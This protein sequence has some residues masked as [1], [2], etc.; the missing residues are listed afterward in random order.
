M[1]DREVSAPVFDLAGGLMAGRI[2]S[3][4][5]EILDDE[6]V[7]TLSDE[8]WRMWVSM[9]LLADDCGN[10]RA[11]DRYLAS[12][13]WQDSTRS[14]RVAEILRELL[15]SRV[16]VYEVNGERYAHIRNWEKHQRIDN[17]GKPRVP[18][19]DDENSIAWV[20]S[21]GGSPNLADSRESRRLTSDLRPPITDLRPT[22][23]ESPPVKP[24]V[25]QPAF[26]LVEPAKPPKP[27]RVR[28]PAPQGLQ[29]G[30]EH[31]VKRWVVVKKPADG[32]PPTLQ[33]ADVQ[34][35]IGLLRAHPLSTVTAWIDRYLVDDDP[36]LAKQGHTLRH[37]G[38]RV[39]AY[40]AT[41]Q[42]GR[43]LTRGYAPA[44]EGVPEG[45]TRDATEEF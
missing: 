31:F 23:T 26:A 29:A 22:T 25:E 35:L 39:D 6:Q 41:K 5:P 36:W 43:D 34:V 30:I 2:R 45:V 7:S 42:Q 12:L 13:V 8:A 21:R 40:R 1:G 38:R 16:E 28:K 9:W 27:R 11:G 17:A 4:K 32:L 10:C 20:P 14:P 24:E 44:P 37:L 18:R 19:P 15:G 3:I 33:D